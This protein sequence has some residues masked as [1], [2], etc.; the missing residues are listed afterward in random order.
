VKYLIII[1]DGAG[2]LPLR[3]LGGLTPFEAASTP[4]LDRVAAMG[5]LGTV[6]TTPPGFGAGSDVCSMCLLGYDPRRYHTGRAPLEAAA[7]GLQPGPRDWIFRLN[8]VTAGEPGA[9]QAGLMLDH[10]AGAISDREA[11]VL[12]GDL[13][14]HWR[15]QEPAL[16]AG[17]TLTPGVSYRNILIDASGRDYS[18]VET[19]PPHEIPGE[20]WAR[21]LPRRTGGGESGEADVLRRLIELS[22]SFLPNHEVNRARVE[23]G[24]RPANMA[25]IWGQGTRPGMP[26]F[27]ERFGLRGAMITSVDLLAGIAAYMGWE[28]LDVPGLTSYHDTDY[29]AQGRATCDALGKYDIVCCHVEAPDEASHQADWQTKVASLEAIDEKIIG[30]VLERLAD[31]GDPPTD[32][33]AEGW[34]LLVLP[35]H[36]TL[37]STRKHDATPVPF[38]MAG[39]WVRSVVPRAFSEKNAAASDLHITEGHELMEYFLRTGLGARK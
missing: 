29:A 3:E 32:P 21:A 13:L 7:L 38:A 2:D 18:Q 39:A 27:K 12:I 8:L 34:R 25:W 9:D 4:N 36:Y 30:P 23:Q 33:R 28:R 20:P 37:V 10:S 15:T 5:R 26:S 24:L 31:F 17:F 16:S 35:D 22:A 1:P 11:R 6:S 19:V 14:H